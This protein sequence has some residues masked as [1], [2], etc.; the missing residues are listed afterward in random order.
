MVADVILR[1]KT[2]P[3]SQAHVRTNPPL[4]FGVETQVEERDASHRRSGGNGVLAETAEETGGGLK[5]SGSG[6]EPLYR[7]HA[8]RRR[9]SQLRTCRLEIAW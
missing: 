2:K 4:I 6:I 1:F 7:L 9:H 8:S 3:I 5:L